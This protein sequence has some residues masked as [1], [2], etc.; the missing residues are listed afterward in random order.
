MN[1]VMW[2]GTLSPSKVENLFENYIKILEAINTRK[3]LLKEK[4]DIE[5]ATQ[6]K[7]LNETE[8]KARKHILNILLK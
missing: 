7:K 6:E 1:G 5:Q 3:K 2:L 8:L 4:F